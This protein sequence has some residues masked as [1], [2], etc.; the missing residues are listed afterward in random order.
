MSLFSIKKR[1]SV[2]SREDA[3]SQLMNFLTH[4]HIDLE[5]MVDKLKKDDPEYSYTADDLGLDFCKLIEEGSISI[6]QE[7]GCPVVIMHLSN[8][9]GSISEL[10]FGEINGACK[11]RVAGSKSIAARGLEMLRET[12]T[13]TG[14]ILD[15]IKGSDSK[16]MEQTAQLFSL[17]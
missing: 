9:I 1:E 10:K 4:Y 16:V 5:E 17:A 15:K 11:K 14:A 2:V 3:I 13:T 12:C 7:S 6:E 8:P